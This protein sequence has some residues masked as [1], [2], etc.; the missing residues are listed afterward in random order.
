VTGERRITAKP[1]LGYIDVVLHRCGREAATEKSAA[2]TCGV[3]FDAFT[4][5]FVSY[6]SVFMSYC[7]TFAIAHKKA[8]DALY[9]RVYE[10]FA[11]FSINV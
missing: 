6:C 4:A 10:H 7:K 3:Q 8:V 2:P 11:Y 1:Q 9:K 5:I